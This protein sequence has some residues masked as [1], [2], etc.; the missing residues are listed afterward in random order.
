ML[1]YTILIFALAQAVVCAPWL[2]KQ[3][4]VNG[5][6]VVDTTPMPVSLLAQKYT[7]AP[8]QYDITTQPSRHKAFWMRAH[9]SSRLEFSGVEPLPG[10]IPSHSS[11]HGA[12]GH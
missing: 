3:T 11:I 9:T 6:W 12:G 2:A 7:S 5:A 8:T 1:A 4:R 10:H